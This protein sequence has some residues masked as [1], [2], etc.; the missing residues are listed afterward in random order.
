MAES[1]KVPG[2]VAVFGLGCMA[3]LAFYSTFYLRN[4]DAVLD[5]LDAILTRGTAGILITLGALLILTAVSG[6]WTVVNKPQTVLAALSIGLSAPAVIV[7]ANGEPVAGDSA[8]ALEQ[9]PTVYAGV[10]GDS[11]PTWIRDSLGLVFA[12]VSVVSNYERRGADERLRAVESERAQL[13]AQVEEFRDAN[14]A[15]TTA[16]Q[17]IAAIE[18]KLETATLLADRSN[19]L[20]R[21][22]AE[23]QSKI[24]SSQQQLA[25]AQ[26]A[27]EGALRDAAL[28]KDRAGQLTIESREHRSKI[29]RLENRNASMRA[30]SNQM[31][32]DLTHCRRLLPPVVK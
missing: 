15:L 3:T 6:I 27:R 11:L 10:V 7:A 23:A 32:A 26:R 24:E 17:Q 29:D 5:K 9:P 25:S 2:R 4:I 12:P 16:T 31:S 20:S 21:S 13:V 8:A 30:S 28:W 18:G 14:R 19:D 1:G 22:L